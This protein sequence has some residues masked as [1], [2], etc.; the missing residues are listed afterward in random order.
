MMKRISVVF[1]LLLC[2]IFS[3]CA[4]NE[5]TTSKN[6]LK[7]PEIGL[8]HIYNKPDNKIP[9][10]KSL[11]GEIVILDF[12]A[13]WCSPCIAAFPGNNELYNKFKSKG[14]RFIA[15]TDDPKEKLEH[16]LEKTN[17]DFW[18]GRDDDKQAFKAYN[19]SGRPTMIII[20]RNGDI[21]YRGHQVT[22]ELIEQVIATN[23][24]ALT[25]KTNFSNVVITDGAWSPGE[26]PLYNGVNEMLTGKY[27]KPVLIDHFIIRPSLNSQS[28]GYGY[29]NS[30]RKGYIGV[31]YSSGK[32]ADI[33]QFLNGLSSA[34][35]VKNNTGDT[36]RY[37]IVYW[38]KSPGLK[39]TFNAIQ[40]RLSEGLNITFDS[41]RSEQQIHIL[42]LKKENKNVLSPGQIEDG[43]FK[44][45]ISIN[46]FVSQLE[47]KSL[48]YYIVD[49]SLR[50]KLVYN[51]G[52]EW[53]KL[54][55]SGTEEIIR[56][57]SESGIEVLEEKRMITLY[58]IN[59]K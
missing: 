46:T 15:I 47:N 49:K 25:E 31:T 53:N 5:V 59:I 37:D 3:G 44:A 56:F 13:I 38:R 27:V 29:N 10:L 58:E 54:Y 8:E 40:N 16:F 30:N 1:G 4:D 57:L 39:N 2:L 48:Q 18:I 51:K 20:N 28:G 17:V 55:D 41:V 9:T 22:E 52:M 11:E 24:I 36:T 14:V 26:D 43:A 32:L 34:I 35:W 33:F 42:T 45:Y 12:W 23:T 21:V 50:D 6:T 7:A 19:I